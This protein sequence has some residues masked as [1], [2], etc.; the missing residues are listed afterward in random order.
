MKKVLITIRG[1][2]DGAEDEAI[3]FMTEGTMRK[4]DSDYI[5]SYNDTQ[6]LGDTEKCGVKTRVMTHGDD[7]VV[8]ERGGGVSSRLVIEKGVRTGCLYSIPQGDLTLGVYGKSIK[9]RITDSG[10]KLSM[11]Y[12][13][14]ADMRHL[15]ENTIEITVKEV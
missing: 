2:Q 3:E 11:T 13:V 5:I 12:T 6:I 1:T 14:D 10:G 15:S 9:N 7:K 8:I 4:S